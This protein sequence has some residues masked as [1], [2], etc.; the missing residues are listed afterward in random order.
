MNPEMLFWLAVVA[1]LVGALFYILRRATLRLG[2]RCPEGKG[3]YPECL[4]VVTI[5]DGEVSVK[6]PDGTET[7]IPLAKVGEI[8][9]ETNDSGPTGADVW[10]RLSDVDGRAVCTFPGGA[11]GEGVAL[12]VFQT[13]PGFDDNAV[14][15]AMGSTSNRRFVVY[16]RA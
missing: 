1:I 3:L 8:V 12:R 2:K 16:R 14:I 6:A 13:L 11:T 9:V 7:R 5:V 15:Q 4:S 10:W